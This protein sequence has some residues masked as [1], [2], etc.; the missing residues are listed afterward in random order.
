MESSTSGVVVAS[1]I[2]C[3]SLE[4]YINE[5][6]DVPKNFGQ[7]AIYIITLKERHLIVNITT[8]LEHFGGALFV[9]REA[10]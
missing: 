9:R 1:T 10:G 7:V 5:C 3:T 6:S 8:R 2:K 4:V